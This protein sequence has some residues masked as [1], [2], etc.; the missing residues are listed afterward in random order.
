MESEQEVV[1]TKLIG[2]FGEAWDEIVEE[3]VG[4]CDQKLSHGIVVLESRVL[5]SSSGRGTEKLKLGF[6]LEF[7]WFSIGKQ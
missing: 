3:A 1:E 2:D 6:E 7:A 5:K 4:D